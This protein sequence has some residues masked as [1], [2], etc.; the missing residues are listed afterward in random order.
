MQASDRSKALSSAT[1][2]MLGYR[3]SKVVQLLNEMLSPVDVSNEDK[4]FWTDQSER[5]YHS[6][7]SKRSCVRSQVSIAAQARH[8]KEKEKEIVMFHRMR[9]IRRTIEKT[10][11]Y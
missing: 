8:A 10:N 9:I 11:S 4:T 6:Y 5:F 2:F 3:H 7:L 1:L